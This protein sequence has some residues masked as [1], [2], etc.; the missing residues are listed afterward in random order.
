VLHREKVRPVTAHE[1]TDG[2]R[3]RLRTLICREFPLYET[4]QRRTRR[5]IPVFVLEMDEG[6]DLGG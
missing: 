4:Y 1:A 3:G 5:T 2:E 6:R